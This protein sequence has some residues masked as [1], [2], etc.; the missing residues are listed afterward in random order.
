MQ[1]IPQEDGSIYVRGTTTADEM[2]KNLQ[3]CEVLVVFE[4]TK[5]V[6]VKIEGSNSSQDTLRLINLTYM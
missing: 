6:F 1:F 3:N 5:G 2:R 4:T